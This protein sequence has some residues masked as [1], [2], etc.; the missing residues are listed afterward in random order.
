VS[1]IEAEPP[2]KVPRKP[3]K[4]ASTLAVEQWHQT[5]RLAMILVFVGVV[6]WKISDAVVIIM[7]KPP[8]LVAL[9]TVISVLFMTGVQSTVFWRVVVYIRK[10]TKTHIARE[11]RLEQLL[12]RNRTSSGLTSEG[13]DPEEH[14]D[15][16]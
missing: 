2:K 12:D 16:T 4:P 9:S 13:G 6:V 10:W 8:W 15:G 5:I 3:R 1:E 14:T 11:S 7:Q